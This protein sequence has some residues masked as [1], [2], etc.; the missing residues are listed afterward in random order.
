[1]KGQNRT[2]CSVIIHEQSCLTIAFMW[3]YVRSKLLNYDKNNQGMFLQPSGVPHAVIE[4]T[5]VYTLG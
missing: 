5:Y 4:A 3:T 1:V 2:S